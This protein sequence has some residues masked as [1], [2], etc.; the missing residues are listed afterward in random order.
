MYF[1]YRTVLQTCELKPPLVKKLL[2]NTFNILPVFVCFRDIFW[3]FFSSRGAAFLSAGACT[4]FSSSSAGSHSWTSGEQHFHQAH[5]YYFSKE[6]LVCLNIVLV[7][8]S[9]FYWGLQSRA[10]IVTRR[11]TVFA[12]RW[13]FIWSA[14]TSWTC[15]IISMSKSLRDPRWHVE[16][17]LDPV[18]LPCLHSR[19]R[20]WDITACGQEILQ[21]HLHG[22]ETKGK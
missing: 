12:K 4:L 2:F 6:H 9:P 13:N 22:E 15:F 7:I 1:S 14:R 19:L 21:L 16:G 5:L 18:F 3:E 11:K 20:H 10:T 17:V 8:Y